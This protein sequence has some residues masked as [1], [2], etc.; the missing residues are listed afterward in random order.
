MEIQLYNQITDPVKAI[1]QLGTMFAKSGMFGCDNENAGKMLAMICLA[2]RQSPTYINRN[3]D[4]VGGKLRKKSMAAFAEFRQA[5]GKVRWIKTGE[6]GKEASA[7]FTFEGQTVQLSF[8]IE[9]ARQGGA[10]FKAGSN[11]AKTPGNMLRARVISNALGM[12]CPE[13]FAGD[14]VGNDIQQ[15][16]PEMKLAGPVVAATPPAAPAAPPA[17]A[18]APSNVIDIKAD[19][20]PAPAR[21]EPPAPVQPPPPAA[22]TA[23]QQA[24][25]AALETAIGDAGPAA[26]K[27]FLA[28]GWL[29]PGEGLES[30]KEIRVKQILTKTPAFL[31]AVKGAA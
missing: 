27:W 28:Q 17:P 26:M 4:I 23:E 24:T 22:L 1:D 19:V 10:N 12:L 11:W 20:Q 13:I 30:L 15:V 29:Q 2:E 8:T 9:Q 21:A 14:D 6:D 25:V 18:V 16:A 31:R 5:G 7:E 3:F